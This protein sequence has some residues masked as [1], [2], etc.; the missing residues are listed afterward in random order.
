MASGSVSSYV[1]LNSDTYTIRVKRN[2]V[3]STLQTLTDID[4]TDNSHLT[5]V[6]YGRTGALLVL[7]ID[8]DIGEP[9]PDLAALSH[10]NAS[11]AGDVDVYVT[12]E[13]DSLDDAS[14]FASGTTIDAGSYRLRVTGSGDKDD[15]RLDVPDIEVASEQ[16]ATLVLTATPGGVLVNAYLLPQQGELTKFLNTKARI[17]GAAGLASGGS[18]TLR[19]DDATLLSNAAV[20][21]I[22]NFYA[23]VDAGS[24]AVDLTVGGIPVNVDDLDLAAGADYT[25]LVWDDAGVSRAS[26]IDDDNFP[27][28]GGATSKLRLLNGLVGIT[29][30]ITLTVDFF[31][32]I[33]G[34]VQ[35]EASAYVEIDSG[36]AFQY[37]VSDTTTT[38]NLWTRDSIEL[39]DNSVYTLFVSGGDPT[40][41][42]SLRRDR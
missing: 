4:L 24:T 38:T 42:G 36:L 29:A 37:D 8:E 3:T 22:G 14:P 34:V 39:Q 5:L 30:P 19:V 1:E 18:M 2:G 6:A 20:G 11:G 27:P 17:R 28:E 32:V 40:I 33:E 10:L 35:S 12:D 9:D 26:L 7:A 41:N 23:Q 13:G 31:P 15:L 16:V 25:I 21:V